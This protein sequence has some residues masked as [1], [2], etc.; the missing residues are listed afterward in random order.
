M[1]FLKSLF[2]KKGKPEGEAFI[3]TPSQVI[4]GISPI[5]VQAIENLFPTIDDQKYVFDYVLKLKEN[6]GKSFDGS[7]SLLCL[8]AYSNGEIQ[9]LPAVDSPVI[10]NM[11]YRLEEIDSIFPKMKNA[12]EWVK[13]ITKSQA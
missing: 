4:P 11:R 6:T 10:H 7:K 13:S 1:G 3:P 9:K 8:L 2:G 12:E 5:V